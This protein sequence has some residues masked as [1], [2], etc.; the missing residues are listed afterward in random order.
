MQRA[1]YFGNVEVRFPS[2]QDFPQ[3][4]NDP[5]NRMASCSTALFTHFILQ[6][7]QRFLADFDSKVSAREGKAQKRSFLR[8][9]YGAF[10]RIHF[11]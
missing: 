9:V 6:P 11:E 3:V 1:Q 7:R 5:I 4:C 8:A 2:K 10:Q